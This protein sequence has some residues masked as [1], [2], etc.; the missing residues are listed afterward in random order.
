MC[1]FSSYL[2][3]YCWNMC[4]SS[5]HNDYCK[6]AKMWCNISRCNAKLSPRNQ[7]ETS[8]VRIY[9]ISRRVGC[10]ELQ[11]SWICLISRGIGRVELLGSWTCWRGVGC[12]ELLGSWICWIVGESDVLNKQRGAKNWT[13]TETATEGKC[14]KFIWNERCA[15]L[16]ISNCIRL[17]AFLLLP[18]KTKRWPHFATN[19]PKIRSRGVN[20]RRAINVWVLIIQ[21]M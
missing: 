9:L 8:G 14:W 7:K 5:K 12:V 2:P 17:F 6:N 18:N 16:K 13:K 11:W 4:N 10:V 15:G 21:I 3:F 20:N 1:K 19:E